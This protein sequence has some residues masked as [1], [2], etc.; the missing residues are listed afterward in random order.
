MYEALHQRT[1]KIEIVTGEMIY[2]LE[3]QHKKNIF[4]HSLYTGR[5]C[6]FIFLW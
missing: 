1:I 4:S 5:S 2:S 6:N 3:Y